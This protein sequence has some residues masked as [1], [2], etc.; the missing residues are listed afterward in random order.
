VL[1]E[2]FVIVERMKYLAYLSHPGAHYFWRIHTG[3]EL[4]RV[5]DMEGRLGGYEIKYRMQV[6]RAAQSWLKNYPG[7][8]FTAINKENYL[9]FITGRG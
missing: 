3:A 2:N 6:P 9:E 4:D 8:S 7:S 5:E 1:R